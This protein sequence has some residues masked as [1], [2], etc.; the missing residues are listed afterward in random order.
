VNKKQFEQH[1]ANQESK[2]RAQSE[3]RQEN[4]KLRWDLPDLTAESFKERK[5]KAQKLEKVL[6]SVINLTADLIEPEK[7]DLIDR[8][9]ELVELVGLQ[10]REIEYLTQFRRKWEQILAY[11]REGLENLYNKRLSALVEANIEKRLAE[12]KPKK[13]WERK[14]RGS[15]WARLIE[16]EFGGDGEAEWRKSSLLSVLL[17][18]PYQPSCLDDI[19]RGGVGEVKTLPSI[20]GAPIPGSPITVDTVTN[21]RRLQALFGMH[22]NRFPKKLPSRRMGRQIVYD[23]RAVVKIMRALLSEPRDRARLARGRPGRPGRLWLSDP[24]DPA[25]RERVLSGIE[26][27]IN[28]VCARPEIARAFLALIHRHRTDSAKK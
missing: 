15:R 11:D 20:A 13:A 1:I 23:W 19:L 16:Y 5:L 22:R 8:V 10:D 27:R 3:D 24:A 4:I 9:S 12:E 7:R 6:D 18:Q 14:R 28:T 21:M 2:A 26:E 17:G 25:L